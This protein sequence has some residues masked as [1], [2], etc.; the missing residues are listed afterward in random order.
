MSTPWTYPAHVTLDSNGNGQ[1]LIPSPGLDVVT[2]T[3][4]VRVSSQ[5]KQPR[6][7]LYIDSIDPSTW[8]EGTYTGALDLTDTPHTLQAGG[9]LYG[10]WTGG[11]AG[12]I[13]TIIVRG[14]AG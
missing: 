2:S 4:A 3:V 11:D 1:V 9:V 13:A 12:A 6:F 7:D 10:V 14:Q 8:L 5:T